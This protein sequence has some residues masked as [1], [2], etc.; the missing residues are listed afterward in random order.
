MKS[1]ER[2]KDIL[3]P[4]RTG[5]KDV[6]QKNNLSMLNG[7]LWIERTGADSTHAIELLSQLSIENN[8]IFGDKAYG[9]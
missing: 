5:K 9:T 2:I 8:N 7:M 4:E 1:A 6:Q 3:S